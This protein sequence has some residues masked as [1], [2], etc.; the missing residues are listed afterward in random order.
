MKT[1]MQISI[2]ADFL[3][4]FAKIPR[5]E[6]KRVREFVEKFIANPTSAKINYEK[7]H[8]VKDKNVRTVR[9]SKQYRAIVLHPQ[10]ENVYVL[11]WVDN[12]DEAMNWAKN[13][14]FTINPY[15]GALQI[16]DYE[17]IAHWEQKN[18]Q[19]L[20]D[21]KCLFRH[22]PEEKLLQYGIP[23]FIIP[24]VRK[25][26]SEEELDSFQPYLPQEAWEVLYMLACGY[27][28]EEIEREL[29]IAPLASPATNFQQALQN[30]DSKR[31]F[32]VVEDA[33][34]LTEILNAPLELW[35]IFLHPSQRRLVEMEA[36]G[37]MRTIGRRG[38]R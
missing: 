27:T 33:E 14:N 22:I 31:R 23:Q 8:N 3:T 9:I 28:M 26:R 7:I 10:Q 21:E 6:Q 34:E 37:S 18:P 36:K 35:R 30:E 29:E 19:T 13:K 15:S 5:K 25:I 17:G 1:N 38:N 4:A 32:C 16:L 24:Q 11:V 2:S 20:E 12:H